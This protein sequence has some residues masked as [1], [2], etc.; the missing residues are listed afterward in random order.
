MEIVRA[1][2]KDA[3]K[4]LALQRS[5]YLSEA[6]LHDDF[7]IPQLTQTLEELKADF[8]SRTVLKIVERGLLIASGQV[9]FNA[10]SSHID[11]MAVEPALQGRGIGSSLL[12]ALEQEFPQ[13]R[14]FELFTGENSTGNLSMYQRRGYVPFKTTQVGNTWIVFLERY[15]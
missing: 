6:K 13:A 2:V 9:S 15:A 12:C 3:E 11:R 4:I 14:R 7:G 10:G 1:T 8:Q 5:A